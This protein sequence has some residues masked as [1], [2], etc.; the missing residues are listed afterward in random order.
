M[1][2]PLYRKCM[3]PVITTYS[4]KTASVL[5]QNVRGNF[6]HTSWE[7]QPQHSQ[8]FGKHLLFPSHA[9]AVSIRCSW[10]NLMHCTNS[11]VDAPPRITCQIIQ[12]IAVECQNRSLMLT[13]NMSRHAKCSGCFQCT[14]N[15]LHRYSSIYSNALS[16][17]KLGFVHWMCLTWLSACGHASRPWRLSS[18]SV[19]GASVWRWPPL[20][21]SNRSGY[22]MHGTQKT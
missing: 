1:S 10:S 4:Y 5:F 2:Y 12:A 22:P 14:V 18:P 9:L 16:S 7:G 21:C 13:W 17:F 11:D 15:I 3:L 6:S 8:S 19:L 20:S